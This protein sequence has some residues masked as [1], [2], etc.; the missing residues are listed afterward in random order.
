MRRLLVARYV[1]AGIGIFFGGGFVA[2]VSIEMRN[3][4]SNEPRIENPTERKNNEMS[5]PKR[6]G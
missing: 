3:P 4:T 5:E 1:E 2:S 6:M